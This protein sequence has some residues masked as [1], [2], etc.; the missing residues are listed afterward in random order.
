MQFFKFRLVPCSCLVKNVSLVRSAK[1]LMNEIRIGQ[2]FIPIVRAQGR[3]QL[4]ISHPSNEST[5]HF[6]A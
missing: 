3:S 4:R 5:I 6:A 2:S 1:E